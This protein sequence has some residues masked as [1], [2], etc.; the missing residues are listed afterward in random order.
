MSRVALFEI[1]IALASIV[2]LIQDNL[3]AQPIPAKRH[4]ADE[5]NVFGGYRT[6][7]LTPQAGSQCAQ[8][9]YLEQTSSVTSQRM[10]SP[11]R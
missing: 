9:T 11:E 2:D 1:G 3:L 10:N 6:V 5:N 8:T 7:C 4:C